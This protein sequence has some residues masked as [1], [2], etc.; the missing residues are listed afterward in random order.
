VTPD[1]VAVEV[2]V[3]VPLVVADAVRVDVTDEV[4][5]DVIVEEAVATHA[6][7]LFMHID[8]TSFWFGERPM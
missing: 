5:V 1:V 8:E 6:P 3:L 7:H 4:T 2:R